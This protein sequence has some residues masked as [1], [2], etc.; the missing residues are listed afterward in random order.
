[1]PSPTARYSYRPPAIYHLPPALMKDNAVIHPP[2][3][4]Q[5]N[6]HHT[7][8]MMHR[9]AHIPTHTIRTAHCIHEATRRIPRARLTLHCADWNLFVS[10]T[11]AKA[12]YQEFLQAA[13]VNEDNLRCSCECTSVATCTALSY[14]ATSVNTSGGGNTNSNPVCNAV[15]QYA[16]YPG[17]NSSL[18]NI[19][20]MFSPLSRMSSTI[21]LGE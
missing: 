5:Q 7:P 20:A 18:C 17:D 4:R 14:P 10:A 2:H 13:T 9:A 8:L 3:L 19:P 15:S 1:M 11:T 6:L 16:A 12:A 21:C